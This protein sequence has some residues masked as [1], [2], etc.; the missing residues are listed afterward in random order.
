MEGHH[1]IQVFASP[2]DA[3]RVRLRTDLMSAGFTTALL[4]FLVLV[5]G[6]GSTL[7]DNTLVFIG[8]L[9]GWLLWLAQA[10][11]LVGVLYAFALLIGVGI[12]A[13]GRL[14]LLRDMILAAALAVVFVL[15]LTQFIDD[16]WPELAFFDLQ[17]TRDTFPAFFVTT[18]VAIQAAASP[19]LTAP[20]RK[21]GWAFILSAVVASVIGGVTTVSD[22]L[23]GLLVGLIAAGVIRYV[24]GTSAGLPSTNR[25]RAGLADLGVEVAELRYA[26]DQ[27]ASSFVLVGTSTAGIPLYING[28]GRDSWNTRRTTRFWRRAWYRDA[29]EQYGSDR[30]QQIEHESLALLLAERSGVSAPELVAVGMTERD[31]ALLVTTR[32]DHRLNDIPDDDVDDDMLDAIWGVLGELHGAGISHGSLDDDHIWFDTEGAPALA[33]FGNSAVHP[34]DEQLHDDVAALLVVTTL[35]VGTDR[36]IAA[37]RRAQSDDALTAMLPMLQTASLS[38]TL[39][40]Q[41]WRQRLKLGD[42]RKQTAA[43]SGA[44]VPELEQLQRVSW[45]TVLEIVLVGFAAYVVIGELADVGFDTIIQTLVDARWGIVIIALILV[46]FTNYT[47]AV[48]LSVVSPKPVPVGVTTVEQFAI[49]FV[50]VAVPSAAGRIATNARYFEKFGI[51]AVTSTTTGAITGLLGFIAQATLLVLAILVG[52]GSIDLSELETGDRGGALKLLAM[53][54]VIF[55]VVFVVMLAVPKWRAW[56]K[57]KLAKPLSQLGDAF[58]MVKSPKVGIEAIVSSM[59]TEILYG[60]GFALCV[61]AV[62]GSVSLGEAIF[63]NVTVSLFAG[64]MP[65]PGGVGVA[66]AGMTAGLTAVGVPNDIAVSAVLI[67]RLISY[68]L[69]PLWGYFCLKWLEKRDY[70]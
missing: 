42:L 69:P 65:V 36:A 39:R 25:V 60:A 35:I 1:G 20:M 45:K 19:H 68:Y 66:E 27:P 33:E 34:T 30:R 70:L 31:D 26:D 16:R 5:A 48:A 3:P 61:L 59:G 50:N 15:A 6:E 55:A 46:A 13:R 41:V 23:G 4:A 7:D 37:A 44:D 10:A 17:Q 56:T 11:Y 18:S 38:A 21:L 40:H 57:E 51:S 52:A 67:Y 28:L 63:I 43:A 47:D 49:G 32:Y 8:T 24:F 62:G 29:G 14:E 64:L 9:P 22:A 53:A 54:V 58:K 2:S 12:F